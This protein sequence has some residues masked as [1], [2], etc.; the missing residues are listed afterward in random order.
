MEHQAYSL[1][2]GTRKGEYAVVLYD[3]VA[4]H[5]RKY[6]LEE[7]GYPDLGG[8]LDHLGLVLRLYTLHCRLARFQSSQNLIPIHIETWN[9]FFCLLPFQ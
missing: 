8:R 9:G 1:L 4:I 6:N 5:C 2:R 7:R 3:F